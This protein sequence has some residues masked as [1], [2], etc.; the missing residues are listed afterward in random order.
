MSYYYENKID[1]SWLTGIQTDSWFS[2]V[3]QWMNLWSLDLERNMLLD[4]EK[5][6]QILSSQ[7]YQER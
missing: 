4:S 5:F 1:H 3:V 6:N 7:E 2:I